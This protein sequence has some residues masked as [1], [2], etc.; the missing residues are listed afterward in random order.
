MQWQTGCAQQKPAARDKHA[1]KLRPCP[2]DNLYRD[3]TGNVRECHMCDTVLRECRERQTKAGASDIQ[4]Q[5]RP[6]LILPSAS[7]TGC[8]F[9]LCTKMKFVAAEY[10]AMHQ[11]RI[12]A[13]PERVQELSGSSSSG[14]SHCVG[15]TM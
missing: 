10:L 11:H 15:A 14:E 4:V 7:S 6:T 2:G 8:C 13:L 12:S 1:H 3:P 9:V 5:I